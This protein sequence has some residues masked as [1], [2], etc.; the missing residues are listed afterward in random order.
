M[1][2]NTDSV[3]KNDL[4]RY[5]VRGIHCL[6]ITCEQFHGKYHMQELADLLARTER[7]GYRQAIE[8]VRGKIKEYEIP[9]GYGSASG[10]VM[11]SAVLNYFDEI[12]KEI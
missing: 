9:M 6:D 5:Q 12:L 4:Y 1:K 10:S 2:A 7:E 8:D 11:K 3:K